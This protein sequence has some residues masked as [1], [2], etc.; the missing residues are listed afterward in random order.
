LGL[1][2]VNLRCLVTGASGFIGGHLVERLV[3]EGCEVRALV[4]R[5]SNVS[6][7]RK[8][9]VE[10]VYGDITVPETLGPAVRDVDV[11]FHLAAYYTFHG[12]KE[13]YWKVNV[14]GTRNMASASL[15]AGVGRFVYC[16][17][18]EAV[19]PTGKEPVT[20]DVKPNPTYEYGRSKLAAE[21]VVR[22]FMG[23]G[24]DATIVRPSGVYGPRNIDDV[25]YYFIML[26]ASGG[27]MSRVIPG[28]GETLIQ[29]VHV[30]D[31][32]Q[33][34]FLAGIKREAKGQTYFI[35]EERAYMYNEVYEILSEVLDVKVK[36][37]HVP[38][39]LAKAMIAPVEALYKLIGKENFM[40]H[41]STIQAMLENRVYSIEKAK[42]ELGYK[43]KY[44]LRR[45]MEDTVKWYRENGI[46]PGR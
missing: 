2:W 30:E 35:T 9:D 39:W 26:I 4:R 28:S 36:R 42:R 25:A 11:V 40:Y 19:G 34:L 37:F 18:T 45:G 46:L 8:L 20:E 15:D 24:L 10:L 6:L 7:L 14:E 5:T 21:E 3:R 44:D 22:E 43:P 31:A 33:G 29:F 27:L 38:G 1:I 41:V 23:R 12:K 17:T 16:S 32:V 13:L